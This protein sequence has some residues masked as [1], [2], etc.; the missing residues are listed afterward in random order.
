MPNG[1]PPD[2][3]AEWGEDDYGPWASLAVPTDHPYRLVVQKMRWI[4]PG[5]FWMGSPD[6]EEGRFESEGPRHWVTVTS[7]YWLGATPVTQALWTTVTGSNPSEYQKG[8]PELVAQR[9]VEQVSFDDVQHFLTML[10]GERT[11]RAWRLP[12][13]TEWEYACRAGS[14][15]ELPLVRRLDGHWEPAESRE[16][17]AWFRTNAKD[18]THPVS[19]L[20]ANALGLFDTLG[21]VWEWCDSLLISYQP[22]ARNYDPSSAKLTPAAERADRV[23]RGGS[24]SS[25]ARN[26]RAAC[27]YALPPGGAWFSCGFRLARG[28]G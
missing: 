5:G 9:P 6:D 22:N 18:M 25:D 15:G 12:T 14:G 26:V 2:W 13:E 24:W 11:E 17:V 27:R 4:P 23:M 1:E 21:N 3:A 8:D 7:G 20:Q 19:Q 10:N 16:A 28:Q